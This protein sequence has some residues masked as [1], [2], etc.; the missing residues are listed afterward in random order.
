MHTHVFI[1]NMHT[2]TRSRIKQYLDAARCNRTGCPMRRQGA[3]GG[4][5]YRATILRRGTPKCAG[6]P[7]AGMAPGAFG[8]APYRATILVRGAPKCARARYANMDIWAFGGAP[9]RATILVRGAPKWAGARGGGGGRSPAVS[10]GAGGGRG[11]AIGITKKTGGRPRTTSPRS[12][13]GVCDVPADRRRRRRRRSR[14][15]RCRCCR[16]RFRRRG[17]SRC[18][19]RRC[20]P[21]GRGRRRGDVGGATRQFVLGAAETAKPRD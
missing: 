1:A 21:R 14:R 17:F 8:G 11:E 16:V 2:N 4:A 15:R 12:R 13:T 3:F 19:G 18:R 7:H 9:Y 20:R 5:H 10:S 6:A